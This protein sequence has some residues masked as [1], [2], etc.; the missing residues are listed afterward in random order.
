M[1]KFVQKL[2]T[3]SA[4]VGAVIFLLG[5]VSAIFV[6]RERFWSTVRANGEIAI[7]TLFG[8]GIL[9]W[10]VYGLEVDDQEDQYDRRRRKSKDHD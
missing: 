3:M 10:L 5:V 4:Q 2:F 7:L 9:W 1:K 8:L 6:P